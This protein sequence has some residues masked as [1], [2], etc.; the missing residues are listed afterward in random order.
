MRAVVQLQKQAQRGKRRFEL[1]GNVRQKLCA[2]PGLPDGFGTGELQRAFD[3]LKVVLQS[4]QT[5]VPQ[6]KGRPRPAGEKASGLGPEPAKLGPLTEEEQGE[7]R[8]QHGKE[9]RQS[10]HRYPNPRTV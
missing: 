1:M 10:F 4:R 6:G 8:R 2:S 5:A 3:G 9:N 7:D